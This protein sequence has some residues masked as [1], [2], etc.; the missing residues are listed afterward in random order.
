MKR[1]I[2]II[3][4]LCLF[5]LSV[6]GSSIGEEDWGHQ[7][8]IVLMDYEGNEIDLN[9]PVP[10]S[11]K[12]TCGVCHDYDEITMAYHF[13]QG[14]IDSDGS[15]IVRDDKDPRKPWLLSDGMYGKW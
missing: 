4:G 10:Y 15:L 2:F 3:A 5:I 14:R 8:D 12:N 11:P 1:G 6:N 13:Q 7:E 9:N